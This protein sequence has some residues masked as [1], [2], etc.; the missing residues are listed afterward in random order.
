MTTSKKKVKFKITVFDIPKSQK[1]NVYVF[2]LI[3]I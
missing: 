3:N 1:S 2:L